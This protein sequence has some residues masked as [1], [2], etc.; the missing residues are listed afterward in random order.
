MTLG[1]VPWLCCTLSYL[2]CLP[3]MIQ[4]KPSETA[5]RPRI[6]EFYKK[7]QF[8]QKY[9]SIVAFAADGKSLA[10]CS[11]DWVDDLSKDGEVSLW[12]VESG[13]KILELR[14][15]G[16]Q[17]VSIAFDPGGQRLFSG[18][19]DGVVRIHDLRSMKTEVIPDALG[20][21]VIISPDGMH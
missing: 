20:Q 3:L 21:V 8:D 19:W 13:K 10:A 6:V 12:A 1:H 15:L 4:G 9:V 5:D 17:I 18:S 14:V 7:L 2:V 11:L 16:A